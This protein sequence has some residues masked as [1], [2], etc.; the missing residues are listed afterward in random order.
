MEIK[1]DQDIVCS[2]TDQRL[3]TSNVDT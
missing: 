3:A 2:G 1:L